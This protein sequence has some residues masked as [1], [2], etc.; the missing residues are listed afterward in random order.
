MVSK[1]KTSF[2]RMH[3]CPGMLHIWIRKAG[4][5]GGYN[6]TP[7]PDLTSALEV[8]WAFSV[9][10]RNVMRLPTHLTGLEI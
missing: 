4:E 9:A 8:G 7:L 5:K 6:W 1:S 2:I 10:H 3:E